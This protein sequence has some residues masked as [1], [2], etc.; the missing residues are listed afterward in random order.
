MANKY[1]FYN[2]IRHLREQESVLL[3]DQLLEVGKEERALLVEY[4]KLEYEEEKYG[5]PYKAPEFDEEAAFWAAK[6]VFFA[7]QFMLHREL[8]KKDLEELLPDYQGK[9]TASAQLSAD[10]CLRFLPAIIMHAQM[11]DPEDVLIPNLERKLQQFH[12]SGIG[13]DLDRASLDYQQIK[14]HPTLKQLYIDRI[15]TKKAILLAEEQE[16]KPLVLAS[17]GLHKE[18]FWKSLS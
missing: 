18:R 5:Y 10:L 11:L 1:P 8:D 16:L 2:S 14:Q 12:Y 3:Y 15:I 7:C 6:T 13:Y 17:L 4:M 9:L